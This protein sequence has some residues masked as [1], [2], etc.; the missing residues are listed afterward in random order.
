MALDQ[1]ATSMLERLT[2]ER[3]G[4]P[5]LR[6]VRRR[7]WV[8]VVVAL[9]GALA[10]YAFSNRQ[11]KMYTAT[12][13]LLFV[14]PPLSEQLINL[15]VYSQI[16]PNRQAATN[17]ALVELPT[18]SRMVGASLHIPTARVQSDVSFGSDAQSDVLPVS[19]TD[20]DPVMAAK[21]ANAYVS[22]YI[23]F[24]ALATIKDL[25]TT[26]NQ[27]DAKL[28]Q[29][30]AAQLTS[31]VAQDLISDRNTLELLKDA[32]TGDA[33]V[34]ETATTPTSPSSPNPK[35]DSLLGLVLGL[36]VGAA[37]ITLLERRDRRI[38]TLEEVE[39]VYRAPVLGTVAESSALRAGGLGNTHDEEA[40]LMIRAQL[41]YIR[42]R[43]VRRV[44]VTSAES[45][46]G[47]TLV[48]LNL[49]RA[50]AK[51]DAARTLLIETDLRRPTLGQLLGRDSV[52][53]LS[54]L[55]SYEHD[56]EAALRELVIAPDPIGDAERPGHLDVLLAGSTPANPVELLESRWMSE[57]LT[58]ADGM[59]ETIIVDTPPIGV[60][61]DAIPLL[62]R[63]DAVVLVSRFGVSRRDQA[64]RLIKRFRSLGADILGVVVNGV[65]PTSDPSYSYYANY[66][67]DG[68]PSPRRLLARPKTR[69]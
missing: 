66:A 49:A 34:V 39:E 4:T 35:R 25:N 29:I 21:I 69:R 5:F 31:T 30:P 33:Q 13:A 45:G 46:E 17:Q 37:L 23:A 11:Q 52:A 27:I 60:V 42:D 12:S 43:S 51:A 28:A 58:V 10:A 61:S 18:V 57:L 67:A 24:R 65:K 56:L 6:A 22:D 48:A 53:G 38:K 26:E 47:K 32:Q 14:N 16:D 19:V 68:S 8:L 54:E 62:R 41:R 7:W 63:V 59:Y 40:F 64:S 55:L 9:V 36:L 20:P 50:A 2:A 1:D 44:L 15:P 3:D